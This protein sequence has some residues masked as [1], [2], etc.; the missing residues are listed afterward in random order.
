MNTTE[1][2]L[3]DAITAPLKT[4]PGQFMR[5]MWTVV[6]DPFASES[7]PVFPCNPQTKRPYLKGGYKLATSDYE[8]ISAWGKQFPDAMVGVPTGQLTLHVVAD[9]DAK[10]GG[11]ET[12]R[13]ERGRLP[14]GCTA[15]TPGGGYHVRMHI[16]EGVIIHRSIGQ[17]GP[18]FDVL[19][20]GSYAIAPGSARADGKA[21]K[22]AE[23]SGW[24]SM[25]GAPDGFLFDAMFFAAHDRELLASHGIHGPEDFMGLPPCKWREYAAKLSPKLAPAVRS[26]APLLD[27][28]KKAL[29]AFVEKGAVEDLDEKLA[30]AAKGERNATAIREC[31]KLWRNCGVPITRG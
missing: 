20:E 22:F 1:K 26:T 13:R 5:V 16:P 15:P 12:Y 18:G 23:G 4:E 7:I 28:R 29:L 31:F 25:P 17:L 3:P 30:K 14:D 9:F 10:S 19:G 6:G 21:Y 27:G 8:Q 2:P 24:D 11:L